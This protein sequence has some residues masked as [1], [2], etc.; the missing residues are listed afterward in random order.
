[1]RMKYYTMPVSTRTHRGTSYPKQRLHDSIFL[2]NPPFKK[3]YDL[4]GR[5]FEIFEHRMDHVASFKNI[6][7]SIKKPGTPVPAD[8]RQPYNASPPNAVHSTAL[9]AKNTYHHMEARFSHVHLHK[10]RTLLTVTVSLQSSPASFY[11]RVIAQ[12]R[13]AIFIPSLFLCYGRGPTQ[14]DLNQEVVT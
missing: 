11:G 12:M 2:C 5:L 13:K 9:L 4:V 10:K 14:P 1:M 8:V 6:M 7:S 3:P